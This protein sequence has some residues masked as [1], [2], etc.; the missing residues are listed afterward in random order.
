M[1]RI[2]LRGVHRVK[3][4]LAAGG[5]REH[6]YAWRGGPKF[7]IS[8]GEIAIGSPEYVAA[9]AAC[10]VKPRSDRLGVP[11]MIDH[12]LD[13]AAFRAKSPRTRADY[14]KW[15]L[16]LAAEFKDEPAAIFEEPDA[17]AEVERWRQAWVSAPRSYDYAGQVV[18]L[19]LNW[20]RN[21]GHIR[22][23]HCDRLEKVYAV[24]RSEIVW[25]PAD[26]EAFS[27]RSPEWVRRILIAACETG[28]RPGDLINLSRFHV[29]PTKAGRH[30]VIRTKKK[31][32]SANI[33]VLPEM[34]QIIDWTPAGRELILVNANGHP[35]TE[36]RASEAVRQ[37]RDKAG[38][39]PKLR[40]QDAR[41][42]AATRLLRQGLSL[43]HIAG[44]MGWGLRYASAVIERY[45]TI[46]PD[47]A[48]EILV[49]LAK[50]RAAKSVNG[51]V[52]E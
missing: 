37:W 40:L 52:N 43:S 9:F 24:D 34:A 47:A 19:I 38:L 16:R 3:R 32:R 18:S 13:S 50:A 8:G 48:D 20:A 14:K 6:H 31:K 46:D 12:Y 1:A 27:R 4:R 15:A 44:H 28:L 29:K 35:L 22:A 39:S 30:I 23:H 5:F 51:G 49:S 33:P 45:A 21:K 41:G 11:E 17:R 7:W 26:I 2:D 25:S 42:T 10:A 36:H